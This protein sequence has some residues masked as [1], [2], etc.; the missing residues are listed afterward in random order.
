M[1]N[2]ALVGIGLMLLLLPGAGLLGDRTGFWVMAI[3]L[4]I[5]FHVVF[6]PL[7]REREAASAESLESTSDAID[8]AS[9]SP[10]SKTEPKPAPTP[11]GANGKKEAMYT[12]ISAMGVLNR[13]MVMLLSAGACA[14][15]GY[16]VYLDIWVGVLPNL[17]L[18]VPWQGKMVAIQ[19]V[20]YPLLLLA[21]WLHFERAAA[22]ANPGYGWLW[23]LDFFPSAVLFGWL[24]LTGVKLFVAEI[25][26][27]DPTQLWIYIAF[28]GS[29]A[30]VAY[31]NF[32]H[33]FKESARAPEDQVAT[34]QMIA[35][36]MREVM[37]SHSVTL[38]PRPGFSIDPN[39]AYVPNNQA[40]TPLRRQ[41]TA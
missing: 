30:G 16:Y 18:Q 41:P 9:A 31:Y 3:F 15:V 40:V 14:L 13:L 10:E 32:R 29:A 26:F 2:M 4:V 27:S 8:T 19:P 1:G 11:V 23:G 37:G 38:Y 34:T 5:A 22:H 21:A 20:M 25:K 33:W 17:G 6:R 28:V 12:N 7:R 24:I 35:D 36:A 39:L